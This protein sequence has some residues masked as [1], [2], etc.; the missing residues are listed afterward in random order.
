MVNVCHNE[1]GTAKLNSKLRVRLL[2]T[3]LIIAVVITKSHSHCIVSDVEIRSNP[4]MS[5]LRS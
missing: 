2:L 5:V 1:E 4:G 3:S